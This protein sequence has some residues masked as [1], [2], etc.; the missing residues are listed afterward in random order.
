MESLHTPCGQLPGTEP[1]TMV[2]KPPQQGKTVKKRKKKGPTADRVP[3]ESEPG[4]KEEEA[5]NEPDK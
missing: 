4:D 2:A 5:T 1:L 3:S